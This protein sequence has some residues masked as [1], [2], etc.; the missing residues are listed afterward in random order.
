MLALLLTTILP[1]LLPVAANAAKE[2]TSKWLG[3]PGPRTFEETLLW[4][5]KSI[6]KMQA[7]AQ[8]DT[9]VG[10]PSQ[11]VVDL[12]ASSRYLAVFA[13]L[14]WGAVAYALHGEGS[15]V[16]WGAGGVPNPTS[17]GLLINSA[18]F[19][20]GASLRTIRMK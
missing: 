14:L 8:L 11:W 18:T 3:S 20:H 6:A 19:F 17:L 9:V 4:E 5:D 16:V 2:A 1:A 12:R 13:I 10:Q 7:I 15:L